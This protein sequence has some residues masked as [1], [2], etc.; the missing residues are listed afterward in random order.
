[1]ARIKSAVNA[2]ATVAA[3][4]FLGPGTLGVAA[5]GGSA[6]KRRRR[7]RDS[8]GARPACPV[9]CGHYMA[10]FRSPVTKKPR[11][12]AVHVVAPTGFE[13]DASWFCAGARGLTWPRNRG[14]SGVGGFR[15]AGVV[16]TDCNQI[17][18][19]KRANSVPPSPP[20]RNRTSRVEPAATRFSRSLNQACY[21]G[22][23]VRPAE[24][25]CRV[26]NVPSAP[27]GY[28]GGANA[29]LDITQRRA[30]CWMNPI[31]N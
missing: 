23:S 25:R 12:Y 16:A 1:V 14:F 11:G 27:C 5:R 21:G 26:R 4:A 30:R 6:A 7:R 8:E 15:W 3:L 13:S 2:N 29:S 31:A 9:P 17:A 10:T 24:G 20:S 28:Q 18:T 19:R 22:V